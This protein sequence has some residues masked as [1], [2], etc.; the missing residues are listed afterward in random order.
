MFSDVLN[1]QKKLK[2]QNHVK[3]ADIHIQPIFLNSTML[4]ASA[5]AKQSDCYI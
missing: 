4:T 5:P 2:I 3:A 1:F